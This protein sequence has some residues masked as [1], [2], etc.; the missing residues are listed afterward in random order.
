MSCHFVC[1]QFVTKHIFLGKACCLS[2]VRCAWDFVHRHCSES[3]QFPIFH[4]NFL[5]MLWLLYH[6]EFLKVWLLSTSFI[7]SFFC[8]FCYVWVHWAFAVEALNVFWSC[9]FCR[10]VSLNTCSN[11]QD[12]SS[13]DS[14]DS[15]LT[16]TGTAKGCVELV[17]AQM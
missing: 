3:M 16:K 1:C 7:R 6:G 9:L 12:I 5:E 14:Y 13:S 4:L 17:L 15:C 8:H 11:P 2:W 10:L